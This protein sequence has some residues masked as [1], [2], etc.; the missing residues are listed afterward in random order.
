MRAG[1]ATYVGDCPGGTEWVEDLGRCFDP[2]ECTARNGAENGFPA[3]NRVHTFQS[4]CLDGCRYSMQSGGGS[5]TSWPANP[6]SQLCTGVFQ[7]SGETCT[8]P[9][10]GDGGDEPQP[11]PGEGECKTHPT[12]GLTSCVQPNGEQCVSTNS[13]AS[14]CWATGETGQKSSG[15][16]AQTRGPGTAEPTPTPPTPPETFD[17]GQKKGP[18]TS[19]TTTYN[20]NGTTTTTTTTIVNNTTTHG[21]TPPGTPGKGPGGGGSPEGEGDEN[22]ASGGQDC[23]TPPVVKGDAALGMIATQTWATRCAVEKIDSAATVTGDVGDCKSPFTVEGDNANVHQ[24]RALRAKLCGDEERI[25]DDVVSMV[26]GASAFDAAIADLDIDP[27]EAFGDGEEGGGIGSIVTTRFGGGGACPA[28]TATVAGR[29][30]TTPPEFCSA[31]AAL[32]LLFIAISTIWA[33]R[34]LGGQ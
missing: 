30:W 31:L 16:D 34:I 17:P 27:S 11:D 28:I 13:G 4:A 29:T 1:S 18:E 3:I 8:V 32:R 24:L 15:S 23:D 12:S 14:I 26:D 6:G 21:T 25:E 22:T 5:C 33:L 10:E 9:P 2:E 7:F 19:T 20:P